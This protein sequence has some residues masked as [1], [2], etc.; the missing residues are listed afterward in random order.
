[1][2]RLPRPEDLDR[3]ADTPALA[4]VGASLRTT[5]DKLLRA[6]LRQATPDVD[7]TPVDGGR[8][9]Q[10][11]GEPDLASFD[12][13]PLGGLGQAALAAGRGTSTGLDG[14]IAWIAGDRAGEG[15]DWADPAD[16]A[17]R[18]IHLAAVQ[19]WTRP[20]PG[21][22]AAIGGSARAHAVWLIRER[23]FDDAD[24]AV[25]LGHCALVIAGLSWPALP[26]ARDWT[27]VGLAGLRTSAPALVGNDGAPAASSPLAAARA[28]WALALTR[29]WCR[30]AGA[31]LPVDAVGALV[32]GA[33]ALW[34]I[35]GD[36]DD[37]P[38][39]GAPVAGL[40]PL[41]DH[42]IASTLRDLLLAWDLDEGEA[43][44]DRPDPAVLRL[45]G[46]TADAAAEPMA[47]DNDWQLWSWRGA[48]VAVA[49]ARI[50][51]AR[52]R[53][54]YQQQDG[55]FQWELDGVPLLSGQRHP[56]RLEIA[57][58]D[59]AKARIIAC[60][61]GQDTFADDRPE[62]DILLQ[63]AR[64]VV[65]DRGVDHIE[66]S[67]GEGW[68]LALDDKGNWAGEQDGRTMV[69][70]LDDDGWTWTVRGNHIEGH[71]DPTVAVRSI[72]EV[73]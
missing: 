50:K 33:N 19:A 47:P 41:S 69:V 51:G 26:E 20:D 12:T 31:A 32:Q 56:A 29:A 64:V 63:K 16:V 57:R 1:M 54:Y 14:A 25:C 46:R 71:G 27:G 55:R 22:R 48:G 3:L 37:L 65:T 23:P 42:S 62:R 2:A 44:A 5:R 18:L 7:A 49:H 39:L 70:K 24:D 43:A 66:W 73:R 34:R 38:R 36:S 30:A 8:G 53:A 15:A 28:L 35:Q 17:V 52:G 11:L 72:F 9:P 60:P 45:A 6:V 68:D 13:G 59:G 61:P 4:A 40:L 21:Q 10:P 58:R 67:L